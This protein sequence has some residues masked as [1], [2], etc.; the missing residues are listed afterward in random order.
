MYILILAFYI[1]TSTGTT[2]HTQTL[3]FNY[4]KA[5]EVAGMKAKNDLR[6]SLV[7]VDWSCLKK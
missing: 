6:S 3:E 7:D 4:L 2:V 5:C 1:V